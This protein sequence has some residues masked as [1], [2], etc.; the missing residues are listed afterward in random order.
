MRRIAR[1][2]V[3][4][5]LCIA[6]S[7]CVHIAPA[8]FQLDEDNISAVVDPEGASEATILE[9]AAACPTEAIRLYDANGQQIHPE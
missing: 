1:I 7:N 6:S 3:D 2:V 5:D 4:P 8:V 9:A